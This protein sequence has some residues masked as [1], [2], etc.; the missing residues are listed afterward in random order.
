MNSNSMQ[1]KLKM[2]NIMDTIQQYRLNWY[3]HLLRI[4][5]NR[6]PLQ[7]FNHVPAGKWN[8]S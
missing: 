1:N 8:V 6:T 4:E 7:L 2:N 5:S 3:D